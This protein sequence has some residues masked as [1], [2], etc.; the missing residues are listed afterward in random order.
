MIPVRSVDD[1]M[2]I[3]HGYQRSMTLFAALSLGVFAILEKG[4]ADAR[5]VARRARA[6]PERLAVLLDALAAM[7]LLVKRRGRYANGPVAARALVP[8][9]GSKIQ[10]LLHHLDCWRDWTRLPRRIRRG[11][12]VAPPGNWRE[13]FIRGMD[14]NARA[15]A[16]AAAR[17]FP[18]RPGEH[19]LD[20]GGGPGTYAAAWAR[21]YPGARVTL[22]DLP[23]TLRVTRR[24]LA[25]RGERGLVRLLAG[26]VLADP[27][28]G[29]Y[30]LVWI[31]QLLHA[32]PPASCVAILARVRA[33]L[34]PGGRAAVQEFLLRDD[35]TSPPG[36]ALFSVHMAAV[37]EGGRAYT[38]R[39]IARMMREAGLAR[40][41][42]GTP[43]AAGVGVVTGV[44]A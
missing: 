16:E 6:D 30:D 5:E 40:V 31:S 43:D 13:R 15:R 23:A 20:L 1:L 21:R 10:I 14:E 27:L 26:D 18:L 22:F 17:R 3:A 35:R 24:I 44:S 36:P 8:G 7:G 28:G 12:P 37:T 25:E 41:A 42:I 4:D 32:F 33:A 2:E 38:A 19:L 11:R 29:P 39:E 9:P 34:A